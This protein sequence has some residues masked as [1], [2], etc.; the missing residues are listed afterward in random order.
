MTKTI[1]LQVSKNSVKHLTAL[2]KSSGLSKDKALRWVLLETAVPVIQKRGKEQRTEA[3]AVQL[4]DCC[5]AI[6]AKVSA[7]Y[8]VSDSVVVEAYLARTY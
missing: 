6:I 4:D 7:Q 2:A 5:T 1:S 8:K 3:L